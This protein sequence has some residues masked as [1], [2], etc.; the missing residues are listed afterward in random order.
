MKYICYDSQYKLNIPY[1]K[2]LYVWVLLS[3]V[4]IVHVC[5]HI[6]TYKD[7]LI[8]KQITKCSTKL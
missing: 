5:V 2:L 1:V 8:E 3:C 7:G 4:V 6:N